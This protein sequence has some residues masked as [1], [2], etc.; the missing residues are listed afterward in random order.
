MTRKDFVL[1]AGASKEAGER[2]GSLEGQRVARLT[3]SLMADRLYSTIP[4]FDRSRF[5][6]ACGNR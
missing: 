3:A 2:S 4:A 1:I 6:A 5:E